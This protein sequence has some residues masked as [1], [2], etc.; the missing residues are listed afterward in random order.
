VHGNIRDCEACHGPDSL[1]NI[2]ADSDQ[3]ENIGI[4][5]P[6]EESFGWG[7]IGNDWDCYGCHESFTGAS[8]YA[9]SSVFTASSTPQTGATIP[10]VS[11]MSTYSVPTGTDI[12][13]DIDG[14]GFINDSGGVTQLSD[15]VVENGA[16]TLTFVQHSITVN[17]IGVTV[18]STLTVGLYDLR[19]VKG[20]KQSNKKI[21]SVIP[22]VIITD[23]NCNKKKGLLTVN[24]SGFGEK[25]AG[26]D[27]Y[28]NVQVDNQTVDIISWTDTLI[29]ASVSSCSNKAAI[30]VNALYGSASND[31]SDSNG[32]GKPDKPC[33]GKGCNK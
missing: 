30:M 20:D 11:G 3:P 17:S 31:D 22:E 21:L 14:S 7:H 9:S 13:L 23:V 16:G 8:A 4:I 19:V 2:Q 15:V 29:T 1:H 28:I 10:S 12:Q 32:G 33:K 18:P 5:I 6:G 26:T 24:G 25:P 27:Q